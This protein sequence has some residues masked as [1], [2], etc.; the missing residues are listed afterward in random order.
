MPEQRLRRFIDRLA[1]GSLILDVC[2]AFIT[3]SSRFYLSDTEKYLGIVN[4][5]LTIIVILS[6]VS[7]VMIIGI[8]F[9]KNINGSEG[10]PRG[11][12]KKSVDGCKHPTPEGLW[13][14][15]LNSSLIGQQTI[16]IC[17]LPGF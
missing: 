11:F 8:R 16:H 9:Y 15:L 7:A 6:V 13:G 14:F 1:Y 3:L 4:M 12:R 10:S 2:I 17:K 5:A